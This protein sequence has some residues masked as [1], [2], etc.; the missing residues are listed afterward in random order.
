M[1]DGSVVDGPFWGTCSGSRTFSSTNGNCPSNGQPYL[2]GLQV[3]IA[4]SNCGTETHAVG[5]GVNVDVFN[6]TKLDIRSQSQIDAGC[7]PLPCNEADTA[8]TVTV[9]DAAGISTTLVL[10]T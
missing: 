4:T 10:G 9:T 7:N 5:V 6:S 2:A 3:Q 8:A 1:C